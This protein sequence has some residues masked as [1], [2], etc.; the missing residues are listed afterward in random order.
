MIARIL[1]PGEYLLEFKPSVA[2]RDS[3]CISFV[4]E[5]A[6]ASVARTEQRETH[7]TRQP[8]LPEQSVL[9]PSGLAEGQPFHYKSPV[10]GPD[11]L[12]PFNVLVPQSSL[13]L[14]NITI[15]QK[16]QL[17]LVSKPGTNPLFELS[18]VLG[19][20]FLTGGSLRILLEPTKQGYNDFFPYCAMVSTKLAGLIL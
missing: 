12:D 5:I 16:Y 8:K 9:S 20:N 18:A 6:L 15:L 13:T 3:E 1:S 10:V 11:S 19:Y 17:N 2:S 4:A 7:L 14:M